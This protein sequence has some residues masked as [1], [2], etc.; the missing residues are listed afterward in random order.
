M[1][2]SMNQLGIERLHQKEVG[3]I[4]YL[5]QRLKAS[6]VFDIAKQ[7]LAPTAAGF[8]LTGTKLGNVPNL[9]FG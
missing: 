3:S 4:Q 8:Y 9:A 2:K 5:R 1:V 7:N 6:N